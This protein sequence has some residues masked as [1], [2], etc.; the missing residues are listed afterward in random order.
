MMIIMC[1]VVIMNIGRGRRN[2][3]FQSSSRRNI[4]TS[5][6]LLWK[7]TN[8]VYVNRRVRCRRPRRCC[9]RRSSAIFLSLLSVVPLLIDV[10]TVIV[11]R[12]CLTSTSTKPV[13]RGT[14]CELKIGIYMDKAV[15]VFK[16]WFLLLCH[17]MSS[18]L[19]DGLCR[20]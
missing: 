7:E 16:I 9:L 2:V 1:A 6:N 20:A 15:G 8:A 14:G 18:Y 19:H 3:L 17:V 5:L 11:R 10:S 13:K 4:V 12:R